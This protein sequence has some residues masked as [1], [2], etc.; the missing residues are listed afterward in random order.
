MNIKDAFAEFSQALPRIA[1]LAIDRRVEV[2]VT[3]SP[4]TLEIRTS[5]WAPLQYVCPVKSEAQP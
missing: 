3:I 5:P 1:E 2:T 4:D